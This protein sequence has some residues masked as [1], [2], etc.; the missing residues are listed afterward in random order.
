MENFYWYVLQGYVWFLAV[1]V[2]LSLLRRIGNSKTRADSVQRKSLLYLVLNLIFITAIWSPQNQHIFPGLLAIVASL[3]AW[4]LSRALSLSKMSILFHLFVCGSL[5]LVSDFIQLASLIK[6]W[7][8]IFLI[9]VPVLSIVIQKE[10]FVR[11]FIGFFG[12]FIYFPIG[13]ISCVWLWHMDKAGFY[14]IFVYLVV[15]ANDV[16]AQIV[17]ELMGKHA[18]KPEISPSKTI[19][20]ALGGLLFASIAG[21]GLGLTIGLMYVQGAVFGAMIGLA[22]LAGDLSESKWK[23]ILGLKDFSGLLGANGG[24]LDRFDSFIF[25]APFAYLIL[26]L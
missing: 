7:L 20:G 2:V 17:G 23:R 26:H 22:G 25:A 19:E 5:V 11:Y 6:I 4:E 13:L 14:A 8:F 16:F 24:V 15:A 3:C 12:A 21:A 18:L 10:N 1:A 9:M